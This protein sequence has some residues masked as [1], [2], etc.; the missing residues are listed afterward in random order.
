MWPLCTLRFNYIAPESLE[1]Q[2]MIVNGANAFNQSQRPEGTKKRWR[3]GLQAPGVQP[4]MAGTFRVSRIYGVG[5]TNSN[6]GFDAR[7]GLDYSRY[8]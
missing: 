6:G 3:P 5:P 8:R 2:A 4:R 7:A 1:T